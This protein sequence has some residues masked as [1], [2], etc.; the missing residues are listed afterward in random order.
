M[1]LTMAISLYTSRVVLRTLGIENYGIYN[2]VGGVVSMFA[3]LNGTIS[4]ATQRFLTFELG[5]GN[6]EKLRKV[7]N[8]AVGIH[9]IISLIIL[10]LSET[11]GLWF[12][13][14]KLVLPADR[15]IPTVWVYQFSIL[16]SIVFLMSMPYNAC[17]I[18][19]EKMGAFAYISI[20]DVVLKLAI[21]FILQIANVDKLILYS[22]LMFLIQLFIRFIYNIYCSRHFDESKYKLEWDKKIASEM[23]KFATW[24]MF[25]GLASV[26]FT[27]GINILLNLFFG[28]AV[29]AARAITV[30]VDHAIQA[31]ITNFQTAINPQIIKNYSSNNLHQVNY[32][33][34]A[35]SKF[36]YYL[37]LIIS[38]P[39][40]LEAPTLLNLWLV[41]IPNH[42]AIFLRIT[43]LVLL[44]NSLSNPLITA[45]NA[46]G[47]IKN[48]Q[49]IVGSILLMIVPTAYFFLKLGCSA[50]FVFWIYLFFSIIAQ[51]ARLIMTKRM[52]GLS[53]ILYVK[54]VL[55][56]IVC[57]TLLSIIIP[58]TIY[59]NFP[60]TIIR[61]LL[62]T[63]ISFL[64]VST[65]I[66]FIGLEK[67]ERV[68]LKKK[69]KTIKIIHIQK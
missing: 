48:Y 57:V 29:N 11:I 54:I 21:V 43:I 8:T 37:L 30:Q 51:I 16:S 34:L 23:S 55:L 33:V 17:I 65:T 42:T 40:F 62:L 3:F 69:I 44:I 10:L 49:I 7:F 15:L 64:T 6:K 5:L 68:F 32:L 45:A 9:A 28:P 1:F 12:V 60:Q 2:I 58:I 61:F 22:F 46:N 47:N 56:R 25:G 36:S 38:L 52:I 67:D 4:G 53:L 31:F 13:L 41:E 26:G 24:T 19:H 50:E 63:V 18:A 39:I 66:F 20:I 14:N 27:Q 59:Y 35:S